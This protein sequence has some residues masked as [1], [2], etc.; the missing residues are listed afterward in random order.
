MTKKE[1]IKILD[2]LDAEFASGAQK[3]TNDDR[4]RRIKHW[5]T[6]LG[7]YRFE[8]VMDAV[9]DL[10]MSGFPPKTGQIRG[11][12]KQKKEKSDIGNYEKRKKFAIW[13]SISGEVFVDIEYGYGGKIEGKADDFAPWQLIKMRWEILKDDES[14]N[15]WDAIIMAS[16]HNQNWQKTA[17]DILKRI[18]NESCL[19]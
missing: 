7:D 10:V 14:A 18:I 16:E 5:S 13:K 19:N 6:E 17:N 9:R 4:V 1:L 15:D 3:M 8:D 2:Y 11:Y 12:L